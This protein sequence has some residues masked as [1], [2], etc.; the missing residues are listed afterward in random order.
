MDSEQRTVLRVAIVGACAS[1]KS[2]LV[3]ALRDAGYD[4][5]H[6]AQDH[7]YVPDMWLRISQPDVLIYLDVNFENIKRRRPLT[8]LRPSDL[9]EQK[10]RLA[11]SRDNCQLLID[12]NP[13]APPE[14]IAQA[15]SYLKEFG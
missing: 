6:V 5:R 7:S 3:A 14:V 9:Q 4:A 8:T 10:R 15:M 11:H 13:L 12:T 1:G 2:T